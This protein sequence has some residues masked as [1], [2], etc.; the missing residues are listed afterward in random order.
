MK[1][2]LKDL[3]LVFI[4]ISSLVNWRHPFAS[5][6]LCELG[7]TTFDLENSIFPVVPLGPHE[8]IQQ[9]FLLT[10][11]DLLCTVICL[12]SSF[13][14]LSSIQAHKYKV[15]STPGLRVTLMKKYPW[16]FERTTTLSRLSKEWWVPNSQ[17]SWD[18]SLR[19]MKHTPTIT[20][21]RH[22]T[23]CQS[24][25]VQRIYLFSPRMEMQCLLQALSMDS[26]YDL[27]ACFTQFTIIFFMV[28]HY[29]FNIHAEYCWLYT[30]FISGS[31]F[32]FYFYPV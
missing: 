12:K 21:A 29:H 23:T 27:N 25:L 1:R 28:V 9:P 5:P 8:N 14:V 18:T 30:L 32:M 10:F 7:W 31:R 22:A 11:W 19:I 16:V 24:K 20:T 3:G 17:M 13:C 2:N 6:I 4:K 26:E 15:L